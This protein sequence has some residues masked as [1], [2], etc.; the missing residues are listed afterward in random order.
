MFR[1][2]R[3]INSARRQHTTD[4]QTYTVLK[5]PLEIQTNTARQLPGTRD[6][7]SAASVKPCQ[8]RVAQQTAVDE[9][10]A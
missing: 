3:L 5:L 9:G 6:S 1:M 4:T 2:M 7:G 10:P 8:V